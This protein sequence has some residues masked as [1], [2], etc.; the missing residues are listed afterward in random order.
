MNRLRDWLSVGVAIL[1]LVIL[2]VTW[3]QLFKA[4]GQPWRTMIVLGG[5]IIL[6]LVTTAMSRRIASPE[7]RRQ[8]DAIR[9]RIRRQNDDERL[10]ALRR[11]A[12]E[13]LPRND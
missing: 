13:R 4:D 7:T 1:S 12:S 5:W 3:P 11:R 2:I 6:G 8:E 10:A 9:A